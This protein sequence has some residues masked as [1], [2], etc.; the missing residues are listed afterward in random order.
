MVLGFP[1]LK[2]TECVGA[3]Q[4]LVSLCI[5]NDSLPYIVLGF[6]VCANL[7]KKNDHLGICVVNGGP[8]KR[9]PFVFRVPVVHV[10]AGIQKSS[11]CSPSYNS[12]AATSYSTF[13]IFWAPC[14]LVFPSQ[15]P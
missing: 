11:V 2:L 3:V 15:L 10:R 6:R 1:F 8:Q 7:Q 12:I 13:G 4:L 5:V 14:E 9:G